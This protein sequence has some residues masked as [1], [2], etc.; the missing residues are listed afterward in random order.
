M[1]D[2]RRAAI[3]RNMLRNNPSHTDKLNSDLDALR[4]NFERLAQKVESHRG[5]WVG[6]MGG[7]TYAAASA[8]I[9]E[10]CAE[11]ER[12]E[13]MM[14]LLSDLKHNYSKVVL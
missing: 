7:S 13:R 6:E 12:V 5:R 10:V 14:T 4:G 11:L 3:K 2:E 9:D 8:R 1:N